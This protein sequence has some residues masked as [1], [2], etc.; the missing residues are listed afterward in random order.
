MSTSASIRRTV[1]Y[2]IDTFSRESEIGWRWGRNAGPALRFRTDGGDDSLTKAGRRA[3]ADLCRDGV[4]VTNVEELLGSRTLFDE[5]RGQIEGLIEAHTPEIQARVERYGA[6]GDAAGA[7]KQ[8]LVELLGPMPAVHPAEP[9]ARFVAHPLIRGVAEASSRMR[10]RVFD[11]NAW[12]NVA[13]DGEATQSQRWHRDLPEDRD[14]VKVFLYVRDVPE[15]AGPL[16]YVTGT[17]TGKGR[18]LRLPETWDGIGYRIDDADV[19]SHALGGH[20]ASVPGPA[21]TVVFANTRGLHRGGWART[22]DRVVVQGLYASRSCNR[23]GSLVVGQGEN[24]DALRHD[25]AILAADQAKVRAAA[26]GVA[27]P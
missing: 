16:S 21:G 14:I 5:V 13:L 12:Y 22:D 20:V 23:P 2:G 19:E 26:L 8:Y 25:F 10:L 1:R 3:V 17:H 18:R 11:Y 6:G 7:D 15:G 4:A 27:T 9:I 24:A